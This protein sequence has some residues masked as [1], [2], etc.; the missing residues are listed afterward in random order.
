MKNEDFRS[1]TLL[2]ELEYLDGDIVCLQEV[3]PS[4]Y[5]NI[6]APAMSK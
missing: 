6:L 2:K 1:A 5:K 4:F 3:S